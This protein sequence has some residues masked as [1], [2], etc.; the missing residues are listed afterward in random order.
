MAK[1]RITPGVFISSDLQLKQLM[2]MLPK[3]LT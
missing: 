2:K 1:S 3:E